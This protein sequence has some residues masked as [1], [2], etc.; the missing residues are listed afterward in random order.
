MC[1]VAADDALGADIAC[2]QRAGYIAGPFVSTERAAL[3]IF[4]TVARS[5]GPA[6][7]RSGYETLVQDEGDV[8]VV[9][10][11]PPE[12]AGVIAFGGGGLAMAI[13]KC[14]GAISKAQYQR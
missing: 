1:T 9:T 8:W 13:A 6:V 14:V 4:E 2:P 7:L 5:L 11:S 10:Q 12:R 3:E